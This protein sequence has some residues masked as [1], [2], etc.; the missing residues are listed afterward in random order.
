MLKFDIEGQRFE[1]LKETQLRDENVLERYDLQRTIVNSWELFK[2]EIGLPN[3]FFVGEE[4]RP[5]PSTQDSIDILGFDSDDSS[6]V[7][8]ELKRHRDKLQLLQGLSYAAMISSWDTDRLISQIASLTEDH[9]ELSDLVQSG[10]IAQDVKVVLVAER[11]DPEIILTADWLGSNYGVQ[12]S[13]FALT[14]HKLDD[15][16][17][18][19][20]DQRYPLQALQDSYEERTRGGP[21]TISEIEWEDVLPKLNYSFAE[22]GIVAC[23]KITAGD[24]ARRRFGSIRRNFDG[25]NWVSL[26]FRRDYINVYLKGDYEGARV[27]LKEKFKGDIEVNSWRDGLSFLVKTESQFE[28]LVQWLNLEGLG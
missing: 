14:M 20:V 22:R 26:N 3:C 9:D 12:I 24:A 2:N 4:I 1:P 25:F 19:S 27:M 6:L 5:H 18:L 21:R 13:A 28:S 16:S 17:F 23:R 10:Q 15:S 7:V 11:F 8:I